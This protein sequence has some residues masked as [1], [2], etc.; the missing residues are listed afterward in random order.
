MHYLRPSLKRI[1]SVSISAIYN[2]ASKI[3]KKQKYQDSAV[4]C[5]HKLLQY[6]NIYGRRNAYRELSEISLRNN[7]V[8]SAK[9][10]LHNYVQL[11][12]SIRNTENAETVARMH[13]AYNYQKHEREA[14][15]L[16]ESNARMRLWL[17]LGA[18]FLVVSFGILLLARIR[19]AY[20]RKLERSTMS[21]VEILRLSHE[22][23]LPEKEKAKSAIEGSAIYKTIGQHI[24]EGKVGGLSENDW[25]ELAQIVNSS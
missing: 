5:Y 14:S 12:D 6:G 22:Q 18:F 17:M 20:R 13:A 25:E 10:Y 23:G 9:D 2:I 8:I 15:R 4:L 21:K 7:D 19:H 1:D 11:Y 16:R 3:Y 24:S